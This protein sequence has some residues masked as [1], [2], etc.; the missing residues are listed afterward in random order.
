MN[1]RWEDFKKRR[2]EFYKYYV[3]VIKTIKRA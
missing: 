1:G 2:L 3:K